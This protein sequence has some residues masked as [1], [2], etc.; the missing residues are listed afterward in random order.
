MGIG[1]WL[2]NILFRKEKEEIAMVAAKIRNIEKAIEKYNEAVRKHNE[3]AFNNDGE[4]LEI[5]LME[6]HLLREIFGYIKTLGDEIEI[7]LDLDL[8]EKYDEIG[9]MMKGKVQQRKII[10]YDIRDIYRK[11]DILDKKLESIKR[12]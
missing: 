10:N 2:K 5:E 9:H 8:D 1:K 3:L 4:L 12:R 7:D 11:L 6:D